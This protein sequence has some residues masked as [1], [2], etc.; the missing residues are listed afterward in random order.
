[1][2]EREHVDLNDIMHDINARIYEDLDQVIDWAGYLHAG[3]VAQTIER[4]AAYLG[5]HYP[6]HELICVWAGEDVTGVGG[7]SELFFRRHGQ[8]Y[9]LPKLLW[10][11]LCAGKQGEPVP[12]V[13]TELE[14]VGS[15]EILPSR[16]EPR[17]N[18]VAPPS[19]LLSHKGVTVYYCQRRGHDLTY[20][21]SVSPRHCGEGFAFDEQGRMMAFDV[22]ML[23]GG[24]S[25]EKRII[26]AIDAGYLAANGIDIEGLAAAKLLN[27]HPDDDMITVLQSLAKLDRQRSEE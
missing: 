24:G 3:Y 9:A 5:R 26:E 10:K 19:Q 23:A 25:P 1:M 20:H 13:A 12:V 21:Y 15:L 18:F 14:P 7:D 2:S 8:L 27:F 22:R 17:H 4:L 6:D 11:W 16:E